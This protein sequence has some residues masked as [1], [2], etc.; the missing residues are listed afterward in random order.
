ML[1]PKVFSSPD[2]NPWTEINLVW[3]SP[4]LL[5]TLYN[6]YPRVSLLAIS[7]NQQ[8]EPTRWKFSSE[9]CLTAYS[10]N[11]VCA[12]FWTYLGSQLQLW[13]LVCAKLHTRCIVGTWGLLSTFQFEVNF[14][15]INLGGF[16]DSF[17]VS[18]QW[19]VKPESPVWRCNKRTSTDYSFSSESTSGSPGRPRRYRRLGFVYGHPAKQRS[20]CVFLI[21]SAASHSLNTGCKPTVHILWK[22]EPEMWLC[23]CLDSFLRKWFWKAESGKNETGKKKKLVWDRSQGRPP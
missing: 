19:W 22:P 18:S 11:C 12:L 4:F 8:L 17:P 5:V 15:R 3:V 21:Y 7:A 16:S 13:M 20:L 2:E 6:H 1:C 9:T 23:V 14:C 10:P